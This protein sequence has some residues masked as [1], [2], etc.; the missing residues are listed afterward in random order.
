MQQDM[1]VHSCNP[2]IQ[3]LRQDDGHRLEIT[4]GYITSTKSSQTKQGYTARLSQ[5]NKNRKRKREEIENTGLV[6]HQISTTKT[7]IDTDSGSNPSCAQEQQRR[8]L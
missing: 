4:L 3:E 2:S 1:V 5:K 7:I 8:W 6:M